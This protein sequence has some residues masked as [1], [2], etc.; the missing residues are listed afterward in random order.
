LTGD[1]ENIRIFDIRSEKDE[2]IFKLEGHTQ[3][4]FCLTQL[5][6]ES[7][8]SASRDGTVI[9]WDIKTQKILKKIKAHEDYIQCMKKV[10]DKT[11]ITGSRDKT[12]KVWND[13]YECIRT[14]EGHTNY[15]MCLIV[16]DETRCI[17]GSADKSIKIWEI[18]TGLWIKTFSEGDNSMVLC[19]MKKDDDHFLSG[20]SDRAIKIWSTDP[21]S[22]EVKK[23]KMYDVP[24]LS[25]LYLNESTFACS[26]RSGKV[27]IMSFEGEV[28]NEINAFK[29]VLCMSKID[30]QFI[31]GGDDLGRLIIWDVKTEGSEA[32]RK[33]GQDGYV[34]C[35]LNLTK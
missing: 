21:D 16:L 13:K 12:L 15:V 3:P 1:K 19:L 26:G 24:V 9:I 22:Q 4:V 34:A 25:L 10:D 28:I 18:K 17:S 5:N 33:F 30:D 32:K 7:F 27:F 23:L 8:A 2:P 29:S 11:F 14:L 35:L 20:G 31:A 6:A